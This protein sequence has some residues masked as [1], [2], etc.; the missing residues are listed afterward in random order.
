MQVIELPVDAVNGADWNA[1]I[2]GQEM[3]AR[4]RVSIQ[5]FG[6]VVPIVIRPIHDGTY[7][8][9]G[10]AQ[11]LAVVKDLGFNTVPCLVVQ[12]DDAHA[13]LLAQALNRVSGEDDLGLWAELLREVLEKLLQEEVLLLLPETSDSLKAIASLGQDSMAGY[14][15]AWQQAQAARLRHLQ[16]Q[17]TS[18]QLDV[19]EQALQRI[20]PM[21]REQ[22]AD[23]PNVRGT[24]LYLL[25]K[26]F[27]ER[28]VAP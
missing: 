1:N 10:G 22:M 17:L 16:I 6:L 11:R 13:R 14:L 12:A 25:C 8:T 21:A 7:E 24:A 20:G 2:M 5:K 28:E 3:L 18:G 26:E 15:T 9:I 19:V 27:L 4:L 23:S